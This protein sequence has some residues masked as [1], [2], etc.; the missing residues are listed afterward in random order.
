[1][2]MHIQLLA[3][4][5][6]Q[7]I[8]TLKNAVELLGSEKKLS[9]CE[10][11]FTVFIYLIYISKQHHVEWSGIGTFSVWEGCQWVKEPVSRH[12]F[13]NQILIRFDFYFAFAK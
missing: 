11:G 4:I 8:F 9:L 13:I 2:Q 1:M 5:L 7:K 6:Q 12:F 3:L 10:I